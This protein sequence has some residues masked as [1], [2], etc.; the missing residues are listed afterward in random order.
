MKLRKLAA[1]GAASLMLAVTASGA[2]AQTPTSYVMICHGGP[3]MFISAKAKKVPGANV[4]VSVS[5]RAAAVGS[6]QRM[7]RGGECA[8]PN[9]ALYPNEPRKLLLVDEGAT[10]FETRC[11][12]GQCSLR[13]SS[14]STSN[15]MKWAIGGYPFQVSVYNDQQG[16]MRIT[17]VGP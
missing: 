7:P 13:T 9:R 16:N 8:W 2:S 11:Q 10:F 4:V 3:N 14:H 17:K 5:F 12:K 15:L 1:L 6:N